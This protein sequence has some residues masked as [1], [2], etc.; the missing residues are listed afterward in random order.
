M[1]D[2]SP[3]REELSFQI[4]HLNSRILPVPHVHQALR[5]RSDGMWCQVEFAFTRPLSPPLFEEVS[6]AIKLDNPRISFAIG[7]VDFARLSK[8][9]IVRTIKMSMVSSGIIL[10]PKNHA[11]LSLRAELEHEMRPIVGDLLSSALRRIPPRNT[12][13]KEASRSP[14]Q[15]G[16]P[17]QLLAAVSLMWPLPAFARPREEER[18]EE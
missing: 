12:G 11:D 16:N 2:V 10:L 18:A 9:H 5:V 6:V 8:R 4:E 7:Y 14:A 1:P 13:Q 15:R 17:V 3:L